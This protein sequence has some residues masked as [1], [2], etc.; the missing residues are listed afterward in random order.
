MDSIKSEL[1]AYYY[2]LKT[3]E[4]LLFNAGLPQEIR[5]KYELLR[6]CAFDRVPQ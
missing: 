5:K 6:E 3:C 4:H 1:D 2:T